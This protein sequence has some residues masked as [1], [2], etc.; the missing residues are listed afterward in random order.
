MSEISETKLNEK[1]RTVIETADIA[2]VLTEPLTDSI[3]NHEGENFKFSA[4]ATRP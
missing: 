2:N 4:L 1:L 3:D